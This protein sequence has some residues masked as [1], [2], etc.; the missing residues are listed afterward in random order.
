MV[1]YPFEQKEGNSSSQSRCM[2]LF[3][4]FFNINELIDL[5]LRGR[6]FTCYNNREQSAIS[7]IAKFLL[8]KEWDN[9]FEEVVQVA[10][11]RWISNHCPIK[12]SSKIFDWGPGPFWF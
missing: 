11:P 2:E 4:D 9:H 7:R 1:R 5:P 12:L 10:L 6:Q 8:S 3:S